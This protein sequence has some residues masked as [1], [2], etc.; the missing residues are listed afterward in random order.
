[1][2]QAPKSLNNG[3]QIMVTMET[4]EKINWIVTLL[5]VGDTRFNDYI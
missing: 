3:T 1:M 4:S 2:P 5:P